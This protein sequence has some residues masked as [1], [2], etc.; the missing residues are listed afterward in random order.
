MNIVDIFPFSSFFSSFFPLV[1]NGKPV[2]EHGLFLYFLNN[3]LKN[4]TAVTRS[5]IQ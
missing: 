4:L 2:A 5:V 3:F 1:G